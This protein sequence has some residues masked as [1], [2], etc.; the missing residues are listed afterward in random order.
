MTNHPRF[1]MVDTHVWTMESTSVGQPF[2]IMVGLP[3]GYADSE[4]TYPVVYVLD[5]NRYFGSIVEVTRLH[6][7]VNGIVP[8][9]VVGVGYD[10]DDPEESMRL[11]FRDV[12]PTREAEVEN[13]YGK[14]NPGKTI[15]TGGGAAFLDF[16]ERELCPAIEAD[17]RAEPG[18]RAVMGHSLAGLFAL[19]T[20]FNRSEV[21]TDYIVSSPSL[22]W[23]GGVIFEQEQAYADSH[24]DLAACVFLSV[25]EHEENAN[26]H[27][28]SR[29]LRMAAVLR[30]QEYAGLRLTT[31]V[32]AGENHLS[33]MWAAFVRGLWALFPVGGNEA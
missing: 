22:W 29:N 5:G 8:L 16:F 17:F 31:N 14:N 7:L 26:T 2:S 12:T 27:M 10:T 13:T 21:F 23:G 33:V 20:L 4:E 30:S 3:P 18:Q 28:V 6:T 1:S 25:G 9:I 32:F 24:D 19:Y 15:E 11:R